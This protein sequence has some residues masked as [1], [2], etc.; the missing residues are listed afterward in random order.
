MSGWT[1][2]SLMPNPDL[3]GQVLNHLQTSP[4]FTQ[5]NT[6]PNVS[7]A[8]VLTPQSLKTPPVTLSNGAIPPITQSAEIKL[9]VAKQVPGQWNVQSGWLSLNPYNKF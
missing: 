2:A 7:S 9:P 3:H 6:K 1:A 4:F 5:L 8:P